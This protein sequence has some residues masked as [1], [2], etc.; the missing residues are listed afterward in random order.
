MVNLT[1]TQLA[2]LQ[3]KTEVWDPKIVQINVP[4]PTSWTAAN[5]ATW[6]FASPSNSVLPPCHLRI[7]SPTSTPA[8]SPAILSLTY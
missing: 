6:A 8:H 4:M 7:K 5:P 1:N 2:G 3:D